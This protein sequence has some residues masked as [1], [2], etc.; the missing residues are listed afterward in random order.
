VIGHLL[1][2]DRMYAIEWETKE[3]YPLWRLSDN[4]VLS[5]DITE[6]FNAKYRL[7]AYRFLREEEAL[8]L[9]QKAANG[10]FSVTTRQGR[11]RA[12]NSILG[13]DHSIFDHTES[14]GEGTEWLVTNNAHMMPGLKRRKYGNGSLVAGQRFYETLFPNPHDGFQVQFCQVPYRIFKRYWRRPIRLASKWHTKYKSRWGRGNYAS[15][16]PCMEVLEFNPIMLRKHKLVWADFS[17][18]YQTRTRIDPDTKIMS[19]ML[20]YSPLFKVMTDEESPFVKDDHEFLFTM[21]W[22]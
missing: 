6:K 8:A 16:M 7:V 5:V 13:Y 10:K 2:R 22:T 3:S 1:D 11:S 12:I 21:E 20:Q 9:R 18:M 4:H 19:W 14:P 17:Y 15:F